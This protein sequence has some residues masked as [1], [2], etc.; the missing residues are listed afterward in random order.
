MPKR[1]LNRVLGASSLELK[2]LLLFGLFLAVVITASFLMYWRVTAKVVKQ[3]N[4]ITGKLLAHQV[5][6][7]THYMQDKNA[8]QKWE[9]FVDSLTQDLID[10]KFKWRFI[11]RPDDPVNRKDPSRLPNDKFERDLL[12]D[13]LQNAPQGGEDEEK[14]RLVGDG[15]EYQYYEPV[16][17][18][19]LCLDCHR[20]VGPWGYDAVLATGDPGMPSPPR[21]EVGDLLAVLQL[22]IP[23]GRT[24]AAVNKY[25]GLLLAVAIITGFLALVAFYVVIRYV[26]IH[27]LRHL[28]Q[29]SD[30]ISHGNIAQR[31]EI[32]TGDEFETLAVAFNRMLRH[33]VTIQ[34]EL[35]QVNTSLDSKVDELAQVN[36]QLYEM[37]R[38]KSDFLAT[39]SHELRTPLNSILGFSDVLGAIAS[40]DEKQKRYVQN[41]Q[42]SG[43]MLL[44]MINNILD[45]AKIESG[46]MEIRLTDFAIAQVIG[47]QC[48]MARP[49]TEKKN[50]DLE[51]EVQPDL[52][53]MH[54]DQA[55]VQQVLNNLLSNAIKFTPEGGR[56]KVAAERAEPGRAAVAGDR[57]GRGHRRRGPAVDLREVPPGPHRHARR[58]RHDPRILRHRPGAVD[59]QGDLQAPGRRSL[60]GKR[61]G[62][63]QHVHRPPAL[64]AG[65][66]AAVGLPLGLQFR[67]VRQA[68]GRPPR[69]PLPAAGASP[70]GERS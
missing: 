64:A 66:P 1:S 9:D 33:L 11:G 31:A 6:L 44:D 38:I 63:R 8:T 3:Q 56:I 4:P 16:R 14:D 42:K 25:W 36:M 48:D 39:M 41:I 19:R 10:R 7:V 50:I 40:L 52:P 45:L 35:R 26:I 68:P 24:Q 69:D 60:R 30:A 46:K 28:R 65:A 29:V 43:R 59:R 67:G 27:P 62:H 13:Y 61:A 37:N 54:Q 49:L 12:N 22:S 51:M 15:E 70:S 17:V 18:K 58:R 53:P 47:A 34:D 57:H 5:L 23:N 2:C 55:R 32:H 21:L 20:T